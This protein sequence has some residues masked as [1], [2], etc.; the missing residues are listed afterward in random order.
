MKKII[1]VA[2]L[3]ALVLAS[4]GSTVNQEANPWLTNPDGIVYRHTTIEGMD[5]IYLQ[6]GQSITC[7]WQG[8]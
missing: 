2:F 6:W 1:K 3:L 5:C 4:C 8:K 7:D